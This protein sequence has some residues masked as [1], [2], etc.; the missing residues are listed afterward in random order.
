MED[1]KPAT[2]RA[3]NWVGDHKLWLALGIG[4]ALFLIVAVGAGGEL[5][6][7]RDRPLLTATVV[8]VTSTGRVE[9]RVKGRDCPVEDTL[10]EVRD[11]Q[12]GVLVHRHEVGCRS[13]SLGETM[14]VVLL[15]SGPDATMVL[16]PPRAW[17]D[18]FGL[19]S[20]IGGVLAGTSYLGICAGLFRL[21][22]SRR[23]RTLAQRFG[24]VW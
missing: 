16:R 24:W 18:V 12:T 17:D 21:R 19:A 15:G 9:H 7:T 23:P 22:P 5:L 3:A 4:L 20:G 13:G 8:S 10:L 6:R 1:G 11:P 14:P 2:A